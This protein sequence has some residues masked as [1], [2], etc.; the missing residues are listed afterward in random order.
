MEVEAILEEL[1]AYNGKLPRA[2]LEQAV[3]QRENITPHLLE[4]LRFARSEAGNLPESYWLH[5]WAMYLLAQFREPRAYPLVVDLLDLPSDVVKKLHGDVLTEDSQR[6]LASV[7]DGDPGPLQRLAESPEADEYAR[8]AALGAMVGLVV[9][10]RRSREETLE[11]FRS[12]YVDDFAE[13]GSFFWCGLVIRST[14]LYPDL[15]VDEIR[16]VYD[17]GLVDAYFMPL[18]EVEEVLARGKDAAL[19][20][21]ARK[22]EYQ[23]VTDAIGDTEW[24]ACFQPTPTPTPLRVPP[25]VAAPARP[26][27]VRFPASTTEVVGPK[28]GRNDPCPCGSRLKYKKCCLKRG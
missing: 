12:L 7:Y 25:V 6:I 3:Q 24:W 18:I 22:P 28:P 17:R 9:A 26:A 19:S 21:L 5:T 10:G 8:D 14:D 23:L 4:A 20:A 2:A 13:P 15:L 16:G 1:K 27:R 11:Y